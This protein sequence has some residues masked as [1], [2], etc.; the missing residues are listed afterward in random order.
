[1]Q[2]LSLETI[3]S[4][5]DNLSSSGPQALS[6]AESDGKSRLIDAAKIEFSQKG[7]AGASVLTIS[8]RA[9]VKQPLLN[10]HFGNKEGLWRAVIENT[11][12]I[13]TAEWAKVRTLILQNEDPLTRLKGVLAA[14]IAIH[15]RDPT[16]QALV[17]AEVAQPSA[18]LEWMV[19]RF[20]KP[21]HIFLDSILQECIDANQIK[22]LPDRYASVMITIM[23]NSHLL[24]ANLIL[25]LYP[26]SL[27]EAAEMPLDERIQQLLDILLNGICV[28]KTRG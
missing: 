1:M 17:Y 12:A 9:G 16:A 18:R 22:Q 7:F 6:L 26:E 24:G 3:L 4:I 19:D 28:S 25:R 27:G 23:L 8:E 15:H 20:V 13:S 5:I 14:F 2:K 10:Y 21:F 11:Y